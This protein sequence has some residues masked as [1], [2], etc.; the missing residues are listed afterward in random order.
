MDSLK[1]NLFLKMGEWKVVT[2]NSRAKF[3][4]FTLSLKIRWAI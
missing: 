3:T 2:P 1:Q 4:F